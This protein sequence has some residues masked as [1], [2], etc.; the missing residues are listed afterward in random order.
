MER[1][2]NDYIH[3]TADCCDQGAGRVVS[4]AAEP[5]TA[6]KCTA[7]GKAKPLEGA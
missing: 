6:A 1:T 4:R 2:T 3:S 5:T 7:G